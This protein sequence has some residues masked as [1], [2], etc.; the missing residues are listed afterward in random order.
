MRIFD[1]WDII[2]DL[3]GIWRR[4]ENIVVIDDDDATYSNFFV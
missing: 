1:H 4:L 2:E 3:W